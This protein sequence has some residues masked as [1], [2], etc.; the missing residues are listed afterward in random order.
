MRFKSAVFCCLGF[1]AAVLV[2]QNSVPQA[3]A[4]HFTSDFGFE[5]NYAGGWTANLLGKVPPLTAKDIDSQAQQD[6]VRRGIECNQKV[7]FARLG[8]PSSDFLAGAETTDCV[9]QPPRLESF[10]NRTTAAVRNS[11]NLATL[12]QADYLVGGQRFWLLQATGESRRSDTG[13]VTIEYAAT[14][15]P[16]GLLYWSLEAQSEAARTDFE[17]VLLHLNNGVETQL[18]PAA[19]RFS[20]VTQHGIPSGSKSGAPSEKVPPAERTVSHHFESGLGFTYDVPQDLTIQNAKQLDLTARA[21]AS[22]RDLTQSET[23]SV[24]CGQGILMA[25]T[26]DDSRIVAITVHF[27]ECIGD[28]ALAAKNLPQIGSSALVELNK[29]FVLSTVQTATSKIGKHATWLMQSAISPKNPLNPNKYMAVMI[30]PTPQGLAEF[31]LQAKTDADFHALMATRIKFDD[32]AESEIIPAM[33]FRN[34]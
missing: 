11:Y 27:Q 31:L 33:A 3:K 2:A 26:R 29:L 18:I 19:A 13:L 15:L 16:Q 21:A 7:F 5:L 34:K 30:V 24:Q 6:P 8:Q 1:S 28:Y 23:K 12:E 14:V 9:G 22:Q 25:K 17:H 10:A 20:A 32:G 4:H